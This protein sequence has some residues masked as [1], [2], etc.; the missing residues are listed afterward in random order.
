MRLAVLSDIHANAA[1]LTAALAEVDRRGA[2]AVV[3]LG[4]V[5]GYGPDPGVCVDLVRARS[6]ATVLGNHD[7]AFADDAELA[8]LPRDGQTAIRLHRELLSPDQ[9]AWLAGLPLVDMYE[10]TTLVHA[11]PLEPALWTRLDAFDAVRN[12]F[13]AFDTA[14]CFVGHS[15]VPAVVSDTVGAFKVRPGR[16]YLINVGSVGQPRDGDPRLSF[17][18]F[19]TDAFTYENVRA[20]YDVAR[21]VARVRERGLPESLG[22]RLV[23]GA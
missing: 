3:C 1:A 2:D 10:G 16:R 17:G 23:R 8:R 9:A 12:Q 13:A 21:T 11:A 5:V 4:D 14:V 20:H 19:D 18:L 6:A 7:A 22:Q 15:H